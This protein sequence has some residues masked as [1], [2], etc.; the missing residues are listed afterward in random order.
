M[1]TDW[2][3]PGGSNTR[4]FDVR[5]LAYAAKET[6]RTMTLVR[7]LETAS[8]KTSDEDGWSATLPLSD[9]RRVAR[10]PFSGPEIVPW[11][12]TT[13]YHLSWSML[14]SSHVGR[15]RCLHPRRG[16][17][18]GAD[19]VD[20][21]SAGVSGTRARRRSVF[22]RDRQT[23]A[24]RLACA[25]TAADYEVVFADPDQMSLFMPAVTTIRTVLERKQQA[26]GEVESPDEVSLRSGR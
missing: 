1:A 6:T 18:V 5:E 4:Q 25:F 15:P 7:R 9:W 24:S 11:M 19:A 23:F 12:P 10:Y 2:M 26:L 3:P 16:G 17:S 20:H 14:G 13:P 8:Q 22:R 21:R